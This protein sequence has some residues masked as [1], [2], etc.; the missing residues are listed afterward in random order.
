M[1]GIGVAISGLVTWSNK[2]QSLTDLV[3]ASTFQKRVTPD[4]IFLKSEGLM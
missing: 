1:A 2:W 3:H 4:T